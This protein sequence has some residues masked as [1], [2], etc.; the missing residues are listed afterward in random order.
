MKERETKRIVFHSEITRDCT[1]QPNS[2][3]GCSGTEDNMNCNCDTD[4]CNE[5]AA[6]I[7]GAIN[8]VLWASATLLLT[9]LL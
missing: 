5:A 2:E 4:Y 6:A 8:K 7:G 3:L 1:F 9:R